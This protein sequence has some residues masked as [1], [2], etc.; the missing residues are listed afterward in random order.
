VAD[1]IYDKPISN[2]PCAVW[3]K[4]I[5]DDE[6]EQTNNAIPQ[7]VGL[8]RTLAGAEIQEAVE[9]VDKNSP[10]ANGSFRAGDETQVLS[11]G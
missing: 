3:L 9:K 2:W 10:E 1:V 11:R 7:L 8:V 6:F 4:E 5:R